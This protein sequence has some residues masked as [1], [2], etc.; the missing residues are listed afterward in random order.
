M[1]AANRADAQP[2][3]V[4]FDGDCD[5]CHAMMRFIA[6]RDGHR[7]F[8]FAP[9][10][11]EEAV[12]LLDEAPEPDTGDTV[13]LVENGRR[14]TRSTAVLRIARRLRFP[15]PLFFALI[16]VPRSVRDAAYRWVSRNRHRLL[17]SG[18]ACPVRQPGAPDG[19]SP[20]QDGGGACPR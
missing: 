5:F 1:H 8:R 7:R 10:A 4:V 18:G 19:R 3:L 2:L 17:G 12:S 11:S 9:R 15:W 14:F 16:V 6:T 20:T 13:V